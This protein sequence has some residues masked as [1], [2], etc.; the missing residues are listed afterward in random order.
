M[1]LVDCLGTSLHSFN[2]VFPTIA[3]STHKWESIIVNQQILGHDIFVC[4]FQA[5][6]VTQP[7]L[8][9]KSKPNIGSLVAFVNANDFP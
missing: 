3:C 4:V 9:S 2:P 5:I 7:S 8:R 1:H 6:L